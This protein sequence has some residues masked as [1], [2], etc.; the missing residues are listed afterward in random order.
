LSPSHCSFAC[1]LSLHTEPKSY[2][3]A[4]KHDCWI[5]AMNDELLALKNTGTW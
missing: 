3:E 5:Q 4:S 2:A 1:S